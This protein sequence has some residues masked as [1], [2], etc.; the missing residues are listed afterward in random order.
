MAMKIRLA[1]G[2]AKKS[3][4][5]RI[6]VANATA[7]RDGNYNERLGSYNPM[8][9]TGHQ[10]R[11]VIKED[12]VKYWLSVGAQPTKRV[13]KFL[14]EMGLAKKVDFSAQQKQAQ[15]KAKA[16]AKLDAAAAA[17]E[18]EAQVEA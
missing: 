16:Q 15:P 8:L 3:P 5:Y 7:P 4:F 14:A 17:K 2:G 1:R 10:E 18:A 9:P 6:V 11:V 12:R 13:Q